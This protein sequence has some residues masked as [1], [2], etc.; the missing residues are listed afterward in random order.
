MHVPSE[1]GH[2]ASLGSGQR[3]VT[4]QGGSGGAE[5]P[6]R[7]ALHG[8]AGEAALPPAERG[9]LAAAGSQAEAFVA[10]FKDCGF[11]GV[12]SQ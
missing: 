9:D 2:T 11:L 7:P 8:K 6:A 10:T 4:G 3:A 1:V 5:C 12:S